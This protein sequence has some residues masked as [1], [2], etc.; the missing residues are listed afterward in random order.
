MQETRHSTMISFLL[1]HHELT[2]TGGEISSYEDAMY[3]RVLGKFSYGK[4]TAIVYIFGSNSAHG[5]RFIA[6]KDAKELTLL[7][8]QS[9]DKDIEQIVTF[10]KRNRASQPVI[11][12]Y[13][14]QMAKAYTYN[15]GSVFKPQLER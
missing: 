8:T 14:L 12:N 9:L 5:K 3:D 7:E 2:N 6:L 13:L 15:A 11:Y 1:A 10:F 4:S